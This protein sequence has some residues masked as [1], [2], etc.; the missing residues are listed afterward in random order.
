M[1]DVVFLLLVFFMLA[2][3]FGQEMEINLP[4]AAATDRPYQGPPRLVEV[5]PDGVRLNGVRT[6]AD[7]LFAVLGQMMLSHSD[8][9]VVRPRQAANLQR[10][11]DVMQRLSEAGYETLVL[12]E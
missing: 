6:P 9:I 4:L 1:I 2:A 8:V 10:V 7:S 5:L 11:V 12:V 3:R